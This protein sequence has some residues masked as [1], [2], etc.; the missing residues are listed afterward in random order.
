[1]KMTPVLE[2]PDYREQVDGTAGDN[3][4]GTKGRQ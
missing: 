4:T 1:M 2:G 3:L